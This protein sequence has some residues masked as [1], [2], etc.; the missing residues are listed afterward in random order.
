[1][2]QP[3]I[4]KSRARED[5]NSTTSSVVDIVGVSG[6]G[7]TTFKHRLTRKKVAGVLITCEEQFRRSKRAALSKIIQRYW[8]KYS[9]FC[10]GRRSITRSSTNAASDLAIDSLKSRPSQFTKFLSLVLEMK[11]EE[12]LDPVVYC[13]ALRWLFGA[14]VERVAAEA[15][16]NDS[17]LWLMDEPLTYRPS[18]FGDG[19][20]GVF[21]DLELFY[22]SVPLPRALIFIDAPTPVIVDRLMKRADSGGKVALRHRHLSREEMFRD[23]DWGRY[24]AATGVRILA[25]RGARILTLSGT[26]GADANIYLAREFLQKLIDP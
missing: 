6:V 1:M 2:G 3:V 22:Q 15:R 10:F 20:P 4:E 14:I 11:L 7:K 24:I 9:V 23:T 26:E 8:E 13:L 17:S 25:E 12:K 19:A 5:F 16:M 18:L 21:N